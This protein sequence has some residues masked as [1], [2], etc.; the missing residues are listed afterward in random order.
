[1]LLGAFFDSPKLVPPVALEAAGPIVE[2]SEPPGV[3]A[4]KDPAAIAPHLDQADV[5]KY[6]EVLGDRRLGEAQRGRDVP[7]GTRVGREIVQDVS[8][9]RFGDGVERVRRGGGARHKPIIFLYRN[10]SSGSIW[11]ATARRRRTHASPATPLPVIAG[12][13]VSRA[14]AESGERPLMPLLPEVPAPA[15]R[16]EEAET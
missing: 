16:R 7:D 8:T 13:I 4:I 12:R 3:R 11:S 10:M 9:P 2:R 1:L 5:A 15:H 14:P 6:P